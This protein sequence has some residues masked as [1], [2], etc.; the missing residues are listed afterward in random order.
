[1][2]ICVKCGSA[3]A[4]SGWRCPACDFA[5][6]FVGNWP[7]FADAQVLEDAK[8][9]GDDT[10]R[11]MQSF[12]ERS[13]YSRSRRRLIQ[14]AIA[15]YFPNFSNFYD[16]GAGTGY[17]LEGVRAIRPGVRLYAS[18]LSFDSLAWVDARFGGEVRLFHADAGHIP[19]ADHFDVI[20][21]FDVLEHIDDDLGAL[22]ALHRA[23]KAGGGALITSPQHMSL[24]SALDEEAGHKRRY[25]GGELADKV[26]AAGFDVLLDT[27]FM[28]TLFAPQYVSRRWLTRLAGRQSMEAENVL[29]ASLNGLFAA[30]LG[31]ELMLLRAG[32][33]FPFG[34]TRLVVAR[35][36]ET[37]GNQPVAD[38]LGD[39][40]AILG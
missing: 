23:A 30:I 14:W 7:T 31:V 9:F 4:T 13:F 8:E 3:I 40:G 16:F 5:P 37:A 29:P 39:S 32:A 17:V 35:K 27:S 36:T 28:A 24:W 1:M 19:Y 15:K 20:G 22:G 18:D 2:K 38:S 34:G 33:R 11:R 25:E 26:R 12:E 21:A 10:F 6:E